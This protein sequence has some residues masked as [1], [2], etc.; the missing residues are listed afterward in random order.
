MATNVD[1]F[2]DE[3]LISILRSTS[4]RMETQIYPQTSGNPTFTQN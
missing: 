1:A 2:L 4:K 3:I